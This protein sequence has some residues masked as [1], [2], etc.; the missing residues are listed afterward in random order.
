MAKNDK[1]LL[2]GI[3]EELLQTNSQL[4][5]KGDA[6]ELLSCQQILKEYDL[7]DE[8]LRSGIV[9]GGQDGGIDAYYLFV[10]DHLIVQADDFT[11]PKADSKIRIILI[12]SKHHDKFVQAP[13]DSILATVTELF[14]FNIDES[15]LQGAYSRTLKSK[16]R[17]TLLALKK[18]ATKLT[19]IDV[20]VYYS[21]RGDS[22]NIGTEVYA[23]SKQ[24]EKLFVANFGPNCSS[25]CKF[26]GSSELLELHRKRP[27]YTL[28]LPFVEFLSKG[29]RYVLLCRLDDY[30][31]FLTD[32]GKLRRY[33]F[34]SNVRD[35][36]GLNGVNQD[37]AR[38]LRQGT[39]GSDFWWLNNGVT[40][41]AKAAS[42]AGKSIQLNNT[43]I[44][45][46]LQSS[47]S[48][49]EHFEN[50]GDKSDE[51]CILVKVIITT[52]SDVQDEIIRA[53]NNQ[54]NVELSSLHA[55]DKI[56]RDIESILLDKGMYYERK[57]HFHTN[58]GVPEADLITP[59]YL[60][61]SFASLVLRVPYR[62][63]TLKSKFMRNP[64]HY[65]M[66][67]SDRNDIRIWPK[68]A[69]IMRII[70]T[71]I[72]SIRRTNESDRYLKHNRHNIAYLSVAMV[73]GKFDY[74]LQELV[75]FDTISLTDDI[76]RTVYG[77]YS[78]N[79][80]GIHQFHDEVR[81]RFLLVAEKISNTHNI[82][83]LDC[84]LMRSVIFGSPHPPTDLRNLKLKRRNRFVELV[85][86]VEERLPAQ[87]WKPGVGEDV[88]QSLGCTY[89]D[90]NSAVN[91][92]IRTGKCYEQFH[93]IC[94]DRNG[95]VV[96]IDEERVDP[97][98]LEIKFEESPHP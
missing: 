11:W 15:S 60:A 73:L 13:L 65:R 41:L 87:P 22:T 62:S 98:S 21:S 5:D 36:I 43:Q 89:R 7:D 31:N 33:L 97:H 72:S 64:N 4:K 34:D 18:I 44:V 52:E 42:I 66:I 91:Y 61:A 71:K 58:Q 76:I 23:R 94:I 59:L 24:I 39:T 45:N 19:N 51:R 8:E 27:N 77:E 75:D 12:S 90:Y 29:Q 2:D 40:I 10:N 79:L 49:F 74:T 14:D 20:D 93:G 30:Y 69:T 85:R 46:G 9:D 56:Q 70:D 55:T 82:T 35:F 92:L 80:D 26:I 50:H 37:I 54:S 57:K 96:M 47:Y 16:R 28:E 6:F 17:A 68:I 83:G 1:F 78:S 3:I 53:T 25:R 48:V 81:V 63:G 38:T 67:F 84:L 86:R 95:D 32:E 88:M